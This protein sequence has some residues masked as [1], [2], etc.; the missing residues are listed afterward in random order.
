M[1]TAANWLECPV[2]EY[3]F[4]VPPEY[5]DKSGKC[6]KCENVFVA[7]DCQL[8]EKVPVAEK[9][10]PEIP[11]PMVLDSLEVAPSGHSG[12]ADNSPP[13]PEMVSGGSVP[14]EETPETEEIDYNQ[15]YVTANK[16]KSDPKKVLLWV[17]VSC[18][19]AVVL[20]IGIPVL[21]SMMMG[22][23]Q[24]DGSSSTASNAS[25]ASQTGGD[26]PGDANTTKE[27]A[28]KVDAPKGGKGKGR[29][30]KKRK[31]DMT[32][33][34]FTDG[35]LKSLWAQCHSG[36]VLISAK[37]GMKTSTSHG[38]VVSDDGKIA[39]SLSEIKGADLVRVRFASP[40]YGGEERWVSPLIATTILNSNA[41]FDLAIIKVDAQT[42]PVKSRTRSIQKNDRAVVPVLNNK[43]SKDFLRMTKLRPPVPFSD[44][45]DNEKKSITDLNLTPEGNDYFTLHSARMNRNAT[46]V[47]VFDEQGEW[48]GMHVAHNEDSKTS[49]L[50]TTASVSKVLNDP[51]AKAVDIAAKTAVPAGNANTGASTKGNAAKPSTVKANSFES[52]IQ[53][54][55]QVDWKVTDQPSYESAQ[56][57]AIQWWNVNMEYK[58]ADFT[59]RI[60]IEELKKDMNSQMDKNF[61]WPGKAIRETVNQSAIEA[62]RRKDDGWFACVRVLKP[63][64]LA[65][66]VDDEPAILVEL[67]ET[68]EKAL[69]VP[70][71]VE[72]PFIQGSEWN[73]FGLN[74]NKTRLNTSDGKCMVIHLSG[75][76]KK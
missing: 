34:K 45:D 37:R 1:A 32:V 64:G 73:V 69:L 15:S 25:Q 67:V 59:R 9:G 22:K 19:S 61:F 43:A 35:E 52:A 65:R 54:L 3:R 10:S 72:G 76:K 50:I 56:A 12:S 49:F 16:Q 57:L 21:A 58:T 24:G 31:A 7:A 39:V 4:S 17:S 71:D 62:F 41:A 18:I 2:C 6:P 30:A 36:V 47:P 13:P 42:Q 28:K 20:L 27:K 23:D 5:L 14:N 33:V 70:G 60:K 8:P 29:A 55:Q 44:L 40:N 26:S 53:L 75:V 46:G 68:G 51:N 48:V 63:A 74:Q 66:S 38:V 11:E